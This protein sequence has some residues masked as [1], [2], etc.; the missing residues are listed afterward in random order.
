MMKDLFFF[1][2][3]VNQFSG[4]AQLSGY[5][6]QIVF[7]VECTG[8]QFFVLKF[9]VSAFVFGGES[10][11]DTARVGPWLTS[12]IFQVFDAEPHFFHHFAV[13]TFLECFS[14]FEETGHQTIESASE[15]TGMDK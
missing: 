13:Y 15:V 8:I 5:F 3:I 12:E 9:D 11:H 6:R 2:P 4:Q 1:Q 10:Y 14:R 7:G